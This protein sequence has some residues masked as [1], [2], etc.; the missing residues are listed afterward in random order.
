M[1]GKGK[2]TAKAGAGGRRPLKT[3]EARWARRLASILAARGVT[4]NA[5]SV[6]GMVAGIL[7][8]LA[9]V[10]TTW[11]PEGARLW[12][13]LGAVGVQ[14]R[15][16][17]NM[18]DGMVAIE[19]GRTSAVGEL[20]NEVPDRIS[21]GA[22]LAGLGMAAGGNAL[23]GLA[24]AGLA[25]FVAYVR[26]VGQAAGAGNDFGGPLAKPQRM[27]VVTLVALFAGLAPLSWQ[28]PWG[29]HGPAFW[30]LLLI[31]IGCLLT[32]ALRL[33]RIAATLRTGGLDE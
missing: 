3:R 25:V 10:A 32:A 9:L 11:H 8:G 28:G 23:L 18:L 33:R 15:L 4:P 13:L 16:L 29:G 6:A 31:G 7:A 14:L 26:A 5:I 27:F 22:I 1:E 20:Y 12:W 19:S 30:A 24:V 2:V 21:D 17:A